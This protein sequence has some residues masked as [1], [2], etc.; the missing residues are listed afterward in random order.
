MNLLPKDYTKQENLIADCL[1]FFG[2]RYE[3]QCEFGP[4]TTDFYIPDIKM[5][6]E[7]DG[8]YGHL[9]KKDVKRDHV[10]IIDHGVEYILHVRDST[11]ER[12]KNTLWLAL[13]KLGEPENPEKM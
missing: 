2:M 13:N 4:Y 5:V 9:Y 6:I 12:I 10:L 11:K 8:K 7:A 3:Q 1:D